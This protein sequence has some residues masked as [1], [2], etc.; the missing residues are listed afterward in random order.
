MF[1]AD[2]KKLYIFGFLFLIEQN[3]Y[4]GMKTMG[5]CD[6]SNVIIQSA[7]LT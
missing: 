4:Q 2:L 1:K 3:K 6:S 5:F 7:K